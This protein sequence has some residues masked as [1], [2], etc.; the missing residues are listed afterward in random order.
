[1]KKTKKT[2]KIYVVE[3]FNGS[4]KCS[5][6]AFSCAHRAWEFYSKIK[7]ALDIIDDEY[8]WLSL[9]VEKEIKNEN[10]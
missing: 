3:I 1:M 9:P 7:F 8:I 5:E 4:G 10:N 6:H 2:K